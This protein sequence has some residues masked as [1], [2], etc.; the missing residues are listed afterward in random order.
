MTSPS[1]EYNAAA[2]EAV[3]TLSLQWGGPIEIVLD[4]EGH[5][6]PAA[7][8]AVALCQSLVASNAIERIVL[9]KKSWMPKFIVSA[10]IRAL[11][12]SGVPVVL[13]EAP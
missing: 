3:E 1:A 4:F 12:A 13:R 8:E 6:P 11:S 7:G 9:L 2:I 5:G 10:V